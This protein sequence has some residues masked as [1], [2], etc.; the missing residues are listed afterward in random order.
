[1]ARWLPKT[2]VPAPSAEEMKQKQKM[3]VE[4]AKKKAAKKK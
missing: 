2:E 1:L 3:A 4:A